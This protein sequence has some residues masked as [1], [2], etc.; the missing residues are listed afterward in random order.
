ML[1]NNQDPDSLDHTQNYMNIHQ[2]ITILKNA[3]TIQSS[4]IQSPQVIIRKSNSLY[5]YLYFF[6][7]FSIFFLLYI[8]YLKTNTAYEDNLNYKNLRPRSICKDYMND[9]SKC[10][11]TTVT[12]I[13]NNPK[14]IKVNNFTYKY[15]TNIIC[16]EQNDNLQLCFDKT[17][18]FSQKCQL[19]LNELYLCKKN[20]INKINNGINNNDEL[21]NKCIS[22]GLMNCHKAYSIVNI[23]KVF[24][25]L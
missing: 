11:N 3:S 1:E 22:S 8:N 18:L 23:S 7:L 24:D 15:N 25:D 5:Y 6:I 16:K 10:L 12:N 4:Q 13:K 17:F 9:L 20:N 2:D 21:I 19:Y 14:L